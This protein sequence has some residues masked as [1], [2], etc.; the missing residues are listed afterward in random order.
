MEIKEIWFEG[1]FLF[2]RGDDNIVYKQS[3]LWYPELLEASEEQ[4]VDYRFGFEG[5][6]WPMLGV[7]VSFESFEYDDAIPTPLQA[8]FMNHKEINISGF[9]KVSGINPTL[10]RDYVNGFKKPSAKRVLEIQEAVQNLGKV[11]SEVDF[12][13]SDPD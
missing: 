4:R 7:D 10:I 12:R 3:L 2:G 13:T 6:H 11:Y 5:I 1:E 8:F 9:G